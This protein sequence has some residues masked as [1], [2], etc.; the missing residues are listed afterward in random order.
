MNKNKIAFTVPI[1]SQQSVTPP[2]QTL[3]KP[4]HTDVHCT[5]SSMRYNM[6]GIT[7]KYSILYVATTIAQLI[8]KLYWSTLNIK[9]ENKCCLLLM[10]VYVIH[11]R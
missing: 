5:Y 8:L 7:V 1:R 11:Y 10:R 2:T 4:Q 3:R 9:K 6:D